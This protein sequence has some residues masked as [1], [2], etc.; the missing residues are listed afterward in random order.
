MG[1]GTPLREGTT[2][3]VGSCGPPP[4]PGHTSCDAVVCRRAGV[5]QQT[6]QALDDE[7]HVRV[8]LG[9]EGGLRAARGQPLHHEEGLQGQVAIAALEKVVMPLLLLLQG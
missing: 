3:S 9:G 5:C 6:F 7:E 8:D 2:W 1:S 4:L